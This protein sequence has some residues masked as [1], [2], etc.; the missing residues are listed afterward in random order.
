[1]MPHALMDGHISVDAMRNDANISGQFNAVSIGFTVP[2]MVET[3]SFADGMAQ[4][5]DWMTIPS[6]QPHITMIESAVRLQLGY[7]YLAQT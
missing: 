5:R 1:M 7:G 4:Y 2:R 6:R 3:E